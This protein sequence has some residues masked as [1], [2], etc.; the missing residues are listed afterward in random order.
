ME[1]ASS[2]QRADFNLC[3][4]QGLLQNADW[5]WRVKGD[6]WY[7][8]ENIN[9]CNTLAA[10]TGSCFPLQVFCHSYFMISLW[11]NASVRAITQ[12][13]SSSSVLAARS[14][15]Y[16]TSIDLYLEGKTWNQKPFAKSQ[17]R[18]NCPFKI[19][20]CLFFL[21]SILYLA[22]FISG[23]LLLKLENN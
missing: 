12:P 23:G 10:V 21:P 17:S 19:I 4:K 5:L 6:V 9:L 11:K 1:G 18:D 14:Q 2:L 20:T 3:T 13:T 16:R 22:F 15:I 8:D 7:S